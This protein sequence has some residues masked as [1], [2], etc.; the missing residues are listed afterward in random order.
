MHLLSCQCV[1]YLTHAWHP[2]C[3]TFELAPS[4]LL[5]LGLGLHRTRGISAQAAREILVF[6]FGAEVTQGLGSK[7]LI[8]RVEQRVTAML[9]PLLDSANSSSSQSSVSSNNSA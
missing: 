5:R 4:L 8:D 1:E 9:T 6:S 7:A 2:I 3:T